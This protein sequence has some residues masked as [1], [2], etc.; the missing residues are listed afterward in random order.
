VVEFTTGTLALDS[1]HGPSRD[2]RRAPS[3][4]DR[5]ADASDLAGRQIQISR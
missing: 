2:G 4:E 3:D 5:A 1:G